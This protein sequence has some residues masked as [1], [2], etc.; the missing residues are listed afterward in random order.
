MGVN[1]NLPGFKNLEGLG[2]ADYNPIRLLA[3]KTDI[4][5]ISSFS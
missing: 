2:F 3:F 4:P 5:M 1:E